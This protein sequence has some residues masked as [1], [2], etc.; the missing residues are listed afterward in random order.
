MH[1][2]LSPN[3]T[4]FLNTSVSFQSFSFQFLNPGITLLV[5]RESFSVDKHKI[6]SMQ[7]QICLSPSSNIW[8]LVSRIIKMKIRQT[9]IFPP[10]RSLF[11]Q[12]SALSSTFYWL[13]P[14]KQIKEWSILVVWYTY[15]TKLRSNIWLRH[16]WH[17]RYYLL[18]P[19]QQ[20]NLKSWRRM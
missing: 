3:K 10:D 19:F 9:S 14:L 16:Y 11:K 7:K 8:R 15:N 5:T 2:P 12:L 20:M 17:K 13:Q 4:I 18:S 1:W 6:P